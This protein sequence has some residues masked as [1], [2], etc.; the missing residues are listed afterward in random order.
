M[1]HIITLSNEGA[2]ERV[3]EVIKDGVIGWDSI[4]KKKDVLVYDEK[5]DH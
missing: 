2:V 1:T 5:L 4:L 3:E